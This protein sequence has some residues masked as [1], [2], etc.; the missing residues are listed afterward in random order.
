MVVFDAGTI[1]RGE[2]YF[3]N[4]VPGDGSRYVRDAIGVDT[5]VV[6]GEVA[7]SV[8]GGYTD[9]CRG[10]ILPGPSEKVSG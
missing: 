1:G 7:W 8:D 2:E 10:A 5:V 4:D 9:A 6:G 3:V